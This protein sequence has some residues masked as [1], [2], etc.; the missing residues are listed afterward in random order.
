MTEAFMYRRAIC[1][2]ARTGSYWSGLESL[3]CGHLY[4]VTGG[5]EFVNSDHTASKA[6]GGLEI[7]TSE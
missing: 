5:K 2:S 6:V 1:A 3:G 4:T 7:K